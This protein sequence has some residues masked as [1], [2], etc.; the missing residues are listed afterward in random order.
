MNA[1]V[2]MAIRIQLCWR[3]FCNRRIFKYFSDL[4]VHKL[5]GAPSEILRSI[6]PNECHLLDKAAGIHVRFRLGKLLTDS[7]TV[8]LIYL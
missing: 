1:K 3:S 5:K 6:I 2:V 7:L 8:L 4:I